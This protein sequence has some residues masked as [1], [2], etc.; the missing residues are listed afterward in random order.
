MGP[1]LPGGFFRRPGRAAPVL[2]AG[3]LLLP[4]GPA[5]IRAQQITLRGTVVERTQESWVGGATVR[6][7]G[8]GP[9]I[10][11]LDGR[12]EFFGVTPGRHTLTV[13]ALGYRSRTLELVLRVDTAVVVEMDPDP[14]VLDSL[15]VRAREITIEGEIL[16]AR[17]ERRVLWAQVTVLP[18][19]STVGAVSGYF[20]VEGVP[21]GRAMT[22]LVESAGFLPARIALITESDTT[23]AVAL[24]PDPVGLRILAQQVE[25]LE[26]RSL[27]VPFRRETMGPEEMEQYPG[28]TAF[29]IVD[30]R[31]RV[32]GRRATGLSPQSAHPCL[33]IDDVQR[34]YA[35]F[36][37]G[38]SAGEVERI[39]IYDG[40]GM[41]RVYTQRYLW[42]LMGKEPPT[43]VYMKIGLMGPTCR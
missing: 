23:L 40:G 1:C 28:W 20:R 6:L 16:D 5:A 32:L 39:E 38:L 11:D 34:S 10:T 25:K 17:N 37:Y 43:L 2:A 3:I 14:I 9:Y 29:D 22:V 35:S 7:S 8:L 18:G 42:T 19:F 33:F 36:L 26:A 31:L 27:G 30:S 12:F 15:L 41:I 21:V 4:V 24:E 13:Q